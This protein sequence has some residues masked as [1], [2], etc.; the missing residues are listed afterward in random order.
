MAAFFRSL[1]GLILVISLGSPASAQARRRC[2]SDTFTVSAT[3]VRVRVCIER[4]DATP[5]V[6]VS[7]TLSANGKSFT[8]TIVLERLPG[9]SVSRAIDD[10]A[11]APLGL[12]SSLHMTLAYGD[13][14]VR[15]E[16]ALLLPGAEPLK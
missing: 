9:A 4:D 15:I 10:A 11:L 3:P 6:D 5:T 8:R 14:S 16:H 12:N 2:S 13:G 1:L 7:E